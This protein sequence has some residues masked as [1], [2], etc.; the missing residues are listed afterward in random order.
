MA[1]IL[2]VTSDGGGNVPPLLGITTRLH[3][4]GHTVRVLGHPGQRDAV[5]DTGAEFA[6]DRH[7]RPWSYTAP[8]ST[9]RRARD[10]FAMFTETAPAQ[11][12][13]AEVAGPASPDLI[14]VDCMRLAAL[15]AAVRSPVPTVT[16]MHS[17]RQYITHDWVRGPIGLLATL[18]GL[19]PT[20]LWDTSDLV[21]VATDRDLDPAGAAP[22]ANVRYTG[23]VHPV[24]R[25]RRSGTTPTVLV[26]LS[27]IFYP[28]Q[29]GVLQNILDGL[30][31]LDVHVVP[32]GGP[33]DPA[34]LRAGS[35]TELR[36]HLP[37]DEVMPTASMRV[38]HGGH[39]T[40]LRALAHDL[41][42]LT[43]PLDSHLDHRRIGHAVQTAGAGRLLTAGATSG[44]IREAVRTL[45]ADGPHRRA[46]E[47]AGARIRATDGR[48]RRGR[49]D[50]GRAPRRDAARQ[51]HRS[52]RNRS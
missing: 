10:L 34:E 17:F 2:A 27:T 15:R 11:D 13:A 47:T 33:V 9:A 21:L 7:A 48:H 38:G 42:V 44:E 31:D 39:G 41:P 49:R 30:A 26:S 36:R 5:E 19:R 35:N 37:H 14:E 8:T 28:T 32:A 52:G 12:V 6:P 51:H 23:A 20:P 22:R 1:Q 3:E 4:R 40:T 24:P 16:L 18:R 25:A 46:A 50:R 43:V 29:K 45:V